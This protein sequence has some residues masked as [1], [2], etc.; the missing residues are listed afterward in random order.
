MSEDW[1]KWEGQTIDRK[2]PLRQFLGSTEH[3]A[4]FLT[5]L[6]EPQPKN[7]AIKFIFADFPG[8]DARLA[9]WKRAAQLSHPNLL[10]I[11][12]CG[13]CRL[14]ENNLL[15]V[16]MEY[17][18]ENLGE[19]LPQR[20]LTPEETREFLNPALDA[21]V[22]L[23]AK[24]LAHGH[25]KPSNLLAAQDCLKL[26]SDTLLP[27][28]A[29][30]ELHRVADIYDAPELRGGQVSGKSDVWS[31]GA[32]LVEGLTQQP[33]AAAAQGSGD[34]SV[35]GSVPDVFGEIARHCLR[36]HE[37]QRWTIGEIAARLNPAPLAAAAVAGAASPAKIAPLSVPLATEPAVPLAKLPAAAR[38]PVR[39]SAT[40]QKARSNS[41]FEYF[42]PTLLGAAVLLGL[43]FAIPKIFHFQ[44]QSASSAP[45]AASGSPAAPAAVAPSDSAPAKVTHDE[46]T[47]KPAE[48]QAEATLTPA[49]A[50]LRT[51]S[52]APVRTKNASDAAG[53]GQIL[54]Q[55]LPQPPAKAMATIQ[56]TVRVVVKVHVDPAGNVSDA[57]LDSPGPSKY[58]AGLAEKAARQWQFAGAENDGHG[59]PSEWLIR[60]EFSPS[61][62]RAFPKQTAP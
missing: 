2:L 40:P 13:R 18:E 34:P 10:G 49:P 42:I 45:A 57:E 1:K 29:Q 3:S 48:P 58:F 38:P 5:Q 62:V 52:S 8:A 46:S 7:A 25:L 47:R 41:P 20:A 37:N 19:I 4:V 60:F 22:Y 39:R 15:Y 28:G 55:V 16:V 21:L 12:D 51:D 26:S 61:G 54:D 14:G 36:A 23:H 59:V 30:A 33:P 43:I 31:L 6:A 56:G 53:N 32:T 17:A 44:G 9:L 11:F 24:G 35:P 27:I 50:V